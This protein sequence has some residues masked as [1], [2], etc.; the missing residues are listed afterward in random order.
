MVPIPAA[1]TKGF[2]AYTPSSPHDR[3]PLSFHGLIWPYLFSPV[4]KLSLVRRNLKNKIQVGIR[5]G[6]FEGGGEK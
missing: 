3:C 5:T 6:P 4:R 2:P 1:I